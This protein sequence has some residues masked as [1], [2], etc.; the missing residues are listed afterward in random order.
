MEFLK[1]SF[2]KFA[3]WGGLVA[4]CSVP[5]KCSKWFVNAEEKNFEYHQK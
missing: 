2:P 5:S 1:L 3:T 4:R